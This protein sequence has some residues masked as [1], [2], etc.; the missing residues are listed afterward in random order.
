M[1]RTVALLLVLCLCASLCACGKSK[2]A[3]KADD[4]I[5][6][7]GEVTIDS[8]EAINAALTY[9][10]TLNDEQKMEVEHHPVLMA[11]Q[12]QFLNIKLNHLIEQGDYIQASTFLYEHPEMADYDAMVSLCGANVL[13]QYVKENG[14]E[15][16][17]G[18]YYVNLKDTDGEQIALWY[19]ADSHSLQFVYHSTGSGVEDGVVMTYAIGQSQ[20]EFTR[21]T[22]LLGAA[23]NSQVGTVSLSRYTGAYQGDVVDNSKDNLVI[24][25]LN[26]LSFETAYDKQ[27]RSYH[28]ATMT[29]INAMLD[30]AYKALCD[31]GYEGSWD[32]MGFAVY[33]TEPAEAD[34]K[35]AKINPEIFDAMKAFI[36]KNG[37]KKEDK[38]VYSYTHET[39]K[40]PCSLTLVYDEEADM[41]TVQAIHL[42][43]FNVYYQ[44]DLAISPT[45]SSVA[46]K[47]QHA[48]I[49]EAAESSIRII[50]G[51]GTLALGSATAMTQVA[52]TELTDN[53]EKGIPQGYEVAFSNR[54]HGVLAAFDEWMVANQLGDLQQL[55]LV[56]Y[57]PLTQMGETIFTLSA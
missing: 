49:D 31:A 30:T 42:Q 56:N 53:A 6:A 17:T 18:K 8:E 19:M 12:K 10:N 16:E 32:H 22:S 29:H 26:I 37:T 34:A 9:Y 39:Q 28:I 48:S 21:S 15:K 46:F 35:G 5:L 23:V 54:I 36:Q 52:F 11:A 27:T 55:G 25:G 47:T 3:R 14:S 1:K 40:Y 45:K 43:A 2:A 24:P 44:V 33:K 51:T 50:K 4:L 57:I 13:P 41:I 7:I 20:L 38:A